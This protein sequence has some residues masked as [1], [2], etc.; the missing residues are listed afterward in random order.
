MIDNIMKT[1]IN[2]ILLYELCPWKWFLR[3][4]SGARGVPQVKAFLRFSSA[5]H[6]A[7]K[8]MTVEMLD[9]VK[10]FS[11]Y[12]AKYK[13]E[14]R[15]IYEKGEDWSYMN[16][17]GQKFMQ[18]FT[19][20]YKTK[21]M[22]CLLAE[23]T[24]AM[25]LDNGVEYTGRLDYVGERGNGYVVLDYKVTKYAVS[26]AWV[27]NSEQMTGG[28]MLVKNEIL[29]ANLPM[30][31]VICNFDKETETINW[32]ESK[33]TKQDIDEFKEKLNHRLSE[34]I[35]DFHPKR[36]LDEFNS[37]CKWCEVADNCRG[38]KKEDK[39]E[40]MFAGLKTSL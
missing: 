35:G 6:F 37:P 15:L 17:L 2:D 18:L 1:N 10:F 13:D 24:M 7:A 21:E 9:P 34:M 4:H 33:R 27:H 29:T 23:T 26:P 8:K 5:L 36:A 11:E 28:A 32:I 25:S 16:D 14:K 19:A 40:D 31:V 12:W 39:S 3:K 30:D 38:K 20:L 22:S